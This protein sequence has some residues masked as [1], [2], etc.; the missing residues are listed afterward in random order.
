MAV[1]ESL[2]NLV[3]A[4]ISCLEVQITKLIIILLLL[5]IIVIFNYRM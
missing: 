4:P 3:F 1:A 2:T 5:K